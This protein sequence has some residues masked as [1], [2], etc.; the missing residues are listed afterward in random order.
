MIV[1]A[2]TLIGAVY[3]GWLSRKRGGNRYDIAQ[4]AAA[5]GVAFALIGLFATI[6]IHRG[7]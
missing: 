2:T 6:F 5:Y 7:L 3:G 1:I 4:Y